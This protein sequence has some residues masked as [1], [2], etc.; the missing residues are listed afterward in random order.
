MTCK[1]CSI[2]QL[3]RPMQN[4]LARVLN[5][6]C[7]PRDC[8][9]KFIAGRPELA[10]LRG[11]PHLCHHVLEFRVRC[12]K[13]ERPL[14]LDLQ[15]GR[16]TVGI[17]RLDDRIIQRSSRLSLLECHGP[18][19]GSGQPAWFAA[20]QQRQKIERAD[21]ALELRAGIAGRCR[22]R[23]PRNARRFFGHTIMCC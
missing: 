3:A 2:R 7:R 13:G 4:L 12:R 18:G 22:W 21:F 6:R 15:G 19:Y 1:D 23:D 20:N 11:G 10:F 14:G 16:R 8:D 5:P 17:N 9:G